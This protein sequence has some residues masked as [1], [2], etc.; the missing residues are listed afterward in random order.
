MPRFSILIPLVGNA[1]LFDDT[2]ASI[3][4]NRPSNCQIVIAHDGSYLDPYHLDNEVEIVATSGPSNLAKLINAAMEVATHDLIA[5][6]RP[7]IEVGENWHKPIEQA[8]ADNPKTAAVSPIIIAAS[9]T[10]TAIA[11]GVNCD[12]GLNRK[13]V[14]TK[15]K[16]A[17]RTFDKADHQL[18]G[19]TSWAAF[20]RRSV[21]EMIGQIDESLDSLYVDLDIALSIEALGFQSQLAPDCVV[22]IERAKMILQESEQ[23]HGLS[24]QRAIRRHADESYGR[25]IVSAALEIIS[26]P[27]NG[28]RIQHVIQRLG[29]GKFRRSDRAFA[30]RLDAQAK[31]A[32]HIEALGVSDEQTTLPVPIRKAA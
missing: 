16:L 27:V 1:R 14:G 15:S 20:Y 4:R 23:P 11:A 6:F 25:A 32:A 17:R 26:S 29:A 13:L 9:R 22:E 7:G 12:F 10:D 30:D 31:H 28:S 2:L 3:L 21:L 18:I 8:F 24:A 19:P 5:A